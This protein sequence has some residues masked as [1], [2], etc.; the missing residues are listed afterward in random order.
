MEGTCCSA[1][2][3]NRREIQA[4]KKTYRFHWRNITTAA[5]FPTQCP[6]SGKHPTEE[7]LFNQKLQ[8]IKKPADLMNQRK[9]EQVESHN[10][11]TQ[12]MSILIRIAAIQGL[13]CGGTSQLVSHFHDVSW[14]QL[15]GPQ[16]PPC[17][18]EEVQDSYSFQIQ[19]DPYSSWRKTFQINYISSQR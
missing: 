3:D 14:H 6:I 7:I 17:S 5:H 9:M 19:Q 1:E 13:G 2:I 10:H 4:I 8:G 16:I 15:C 18:L 11:Q 12:N